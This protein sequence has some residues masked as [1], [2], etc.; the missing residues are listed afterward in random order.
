M[1]TYVLSQPDPAGPFATVLRVA[2]DLCSP[3][4]GAVIERLKLE[5]DRAESAPVEAATMGAVAAP[6]VGAGSSAPHP[7]GQQVIALRVEDSDG[8]AE[9]GVE[10]SFSAHEIGN[11][12]GELVRRVCDKLHLGKGLGAL[13]KR[14]W[15]PHC[16]LASPC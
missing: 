6:P 7:H 11:D 8:L 3:L 14:L 15:R 12:M 9:T 1:L 10:L 4:T 2:Q 5:R 16:S 13:T